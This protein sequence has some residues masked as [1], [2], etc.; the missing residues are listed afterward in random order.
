MVKKN[1]TC[2]DFLFVCVCVSAAN[3]RA[4]ACVFCHYITHPSKHTDNHF[5]WPRNPH[6]ITS[7]IFNLG[8]RDKHS[9]LRGEWRSAITVFPISHYSHFF[10]TAVHMLLVRAFFAIILPSH[11]AIIDHRDFKRY[12]WAAE[13]AV[14]APNQKNNIHGRKKK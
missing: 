12:I 10:P 8:D 11:L 6:A 2:G 3:T 1:D 5:L 9:P 14:V 13:Q 7:S 4:F